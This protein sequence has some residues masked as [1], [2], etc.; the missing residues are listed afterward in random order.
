MPCAPRPLA[1]LALA[2]ATSAT[3]AMTSPSWAQSDSETAPAYDASTVVATVNGREVRLGELILVRASLPQ[4]YQQIPADALYD[5]ILTQVINETILAEQAT[6]QGIDKRSDVALTISAGVRSATA[7][8]MLRKMVADR[9]TDEVMQAV[10]E[11]R[12]VKADPVEEIRASHILVADEEKAA[13]LKAEL[14]GGAE[15]AALAAEHGTDGTR[16][17]GGDLGWFEHGAMVPGF[18]DAAFALET[19]ATSDPVQTRFGWHLIK[20]VDRRT[21]PVPPFEEVRGAIAE[22]LS[23]QFVQTTLEGLREG[24]EVSTPNAPPPPEAVFEDRLLQPQ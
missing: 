11:T 23:Q 22:E 16:T 20:L 21:K 3:I 17:N 4:N 1:L 6:A 14:D 9:M 15:F 5:A 2:A 10:Y 18:A 7:D 8:A 13:A 12:Y 24:A 19:G